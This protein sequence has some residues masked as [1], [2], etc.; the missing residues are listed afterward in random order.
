MAPFGL[1][2]FLKLRGW[3]AG[4]S[5]GDQ[6]LSSSVSNNDTKSSSTETNGTPLTNGIPQIIGVFIAPSIEYIVAVLSIL[7][8]G[9]AF[10]PLDPSWPEERL[11][12]VISSSKT[13][14]I[15]KDKPSCSTEVDMILHKGGCS[16][17]YVSME[18]SLKEN[19]ACDLDWPCERK[20]PRRFCYLMYTSGSTG[21]PKG[22]CGTERGNMIASH[23]LCS[24]HYAR[25]VDLNMLS[26][27]SCFIRRHFV[28]CVPSI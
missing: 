18:A 24:N 15:L 8:C 16:V 27:L 28:F 19:G 13:V 6:T 14:I 21:K 23:G 7:R 9:E 10:L 1:F 20:I 4:F 17:M 2:I 12:H 26:N 25:C 5:H 3:T 11:L 22:V